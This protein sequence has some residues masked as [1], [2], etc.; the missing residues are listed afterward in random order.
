M[1]II[2]VVF[3][4]ISVVFGLAIDYFNVEQLLSTVTGL[5][6]NYGL[7][8]VI[9]LFNAYILMYLGVKVGG[10]RKKYGVDY[11]DMYADV[12]HAKNKKNANIFNCI[13]RAHQNSL[14]QQPMFLTVSALASQKYP[15]VAGVAGFVVCIGRLAYAAGYSTGDPKKRSAGF[16]GYFGLLA[17]LGCSWLVCFEQLGFDTNVI[18]KLIK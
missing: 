12:H 1:S 11:P 2:I 18:G 10:A 7:I 4:A 8:G 6:S 14:E 16:F 9:M 15:L 3:T 17:L 5:Q 13:Q